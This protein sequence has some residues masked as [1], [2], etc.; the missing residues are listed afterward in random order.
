[1]KNKKEIKTLVAYYS[2]RGNTK[3]IAERIATALGA[4]IVE[5]QPQKPYSIDYN[6]VVEQGEREVEQGF[7]P[8]LKP[9]AVNTADYNRI[10]VGSPTWWYSPAP[11]VMSFL[12]I[13]NLE[14][15][16]VIPFMTHAGWP[17]HVIKDMTTAARRQGAFVTLAHE[18]RFSA[19]DGHRH[20]MMTSD[21]DLE[22]WI[23]SLKKE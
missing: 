18:F 21:R 3:A 4:D 19:A 22:Q 20:E 1:M 9:L 14:G 7:L 16:T 23:G 13:S 11:V 10:V 8:P 2:Y 6:H 15:K 5:L 12:S 17:E